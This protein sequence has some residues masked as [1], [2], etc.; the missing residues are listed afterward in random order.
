MKL[1]LVFCFGIACRQSC[2]AVTVDA[3]AEKI[4]ALTP[5]GSVLLNDEEG[6]P[7]FAHNPQ[8]T[9][10]PASIIKIVTALAAYDILGK[11]FRFKTEFFL[12]DDNNLAIKGW[13]DPFLISEEIEVTASIL[14][15]TLPSPINRIYADLSSF[16]SNLSIP[17]RSTTLN[18]YDALNGALVVNF[19]SLFI[20]K[21]RDGRVYSAEKATP[22]TPLAIKKGSLIKTGTE[23]RINLTDQPEESLQYAGELFSAFLQGEGIDCLQDK[24]GRTV[25]DD[26]WRLIHRHFNSRSLDFIFSGLMKYSNNY[27]ANQVFLV[28]GAEKLGYPASPD[29]SRKVFKDY[30][31]AKW[32]FDPLKVK[33]EEASG[34]SRNNR[35]SGQQM[36]TVLES[37]RPYSHLLADKNGTRLKSGTLTGVYNYAGYISTTKGLRPFVIITNQKTNRR[38]GIL[39]LLQQIDN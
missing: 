17:G 10:V 39:R 24:V 37:F 32:Q 29:K 34:I 36:M 16:D 2:F 38:D 22:I 11:D 1:V 12:D 6:K 25:V 4:N 3:I 20:G 18:P 33:L 26:S 31:T 19:N 15:K 30:L 35:M 21:T 28:L 5:T 7:L 8:Q 13:G 9:L 23:E 14:A 27:I